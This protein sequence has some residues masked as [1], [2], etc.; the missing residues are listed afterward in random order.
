MARSPWIVPPTAIATCWSGQSWSHRG[1]AGAIAAAPHALLAR[2][3]ARGTDTPLE[4]FARARLFAPL[5]IPRTEWLHDGEGVATAASGLRMTPRDLARIGMMVMSGGIWHGRQIVPA[6]WLTAV[7]TP[8]VSLPD[9]QRYG[10]QWYLRSVRRGDQ[11][12]A[13]RTAIGN[14]GQRLCLLPELDLVVAITAGNYDTPDGWRPPTAVL[15]DVLLPAL[16]ND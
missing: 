11:W 4:D 7:F 8:A 13:L 9:G 2:L 5:A 14:G 10:Y 3:I 12:Q 1:S 6:A 15:R 16:R